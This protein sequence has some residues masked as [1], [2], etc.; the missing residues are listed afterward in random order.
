MISDPTAVTPMSYP[1]LGWKRLV[2]GGINFPHVAFAVVDRG[3]G[4]AIVYAYSYKNGASYY[5]PCNQP[6]RAAR[7]AIYF[8]QHHGG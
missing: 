3:D 4:Q 7:W 5:R 2:G 6:E 8:A 1:H